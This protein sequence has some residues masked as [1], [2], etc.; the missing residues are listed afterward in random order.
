MWVETPEYIKLTKEKWIDNLKFNEQ[1]LS[2]VISD[3]SWKNYDQLSWLIFWDL[4]NVQKNIDD[5]VDLWLTDFSWSINIDEKK[6]DNF[7][8]NKFDSINI[9]I[10]EYINSKWQNFSDLKVK[11][12][13]LSK[14]NLKR[15]IEWF[16]SNSWNW[17][18]SI[19]TAKYALFKEWFERRKILKQMDN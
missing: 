13:S 19:D 11:L 9:A 18:L 2:S 1:K 6:L 4:K 17:W 10:K 8:K 16:I 15:E 5:L 14:S 3:I 7:L 12:Q